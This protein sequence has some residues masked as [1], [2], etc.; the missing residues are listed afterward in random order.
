MYF[1]GF[2]DE[3]SPKLDLQ[4]KATKELGWKHIETRSLFER[5]LAY[6]SDEEFYIVCSKLNESGISFNC[7]GSGIANWSQPITESPEKSYDEMKKAIPR[8]KTLGI[9]L[10]RIMSYAVPEELKGKDFLNEVVKRLRII[11]GMAENAGITC[12][13]ENC[14]NW[15]G[16]SAENTLRLLEAID[17][18]NLKL[19]FDT[20]N[21]VFTDNISGQPPYKKQSSWEFYNTVKDHIAYIHIKDGIWDEKTGKSIFTFPGEGAGD[22]V[23]IVA[24]LLRR[25][26]DGGISIEPHVANVFHDKN[27]ET[28]KEEIAYSSYIEYGRR[29][30]KIVDDIKNH[31]EQQ[32]MA[33]ASDMSMAAAVL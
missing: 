9:K 11:V 25:G 33:M 10:V 20:G 1:T 32:N 21:P 17:S 15:G 14:M 31:S 3:A 29:M 18:P 23:R 22:V 8:M 5:N 28:T 4:I 7:Y 27:P 13:H 12:V 24:D 26:Y 6:I 2:A 19:V 30:M 16:Q